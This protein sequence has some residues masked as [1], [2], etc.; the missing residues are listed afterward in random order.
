LCGGG[1]VWQWLLGSIPY[2]LVIYTSCGSKTCINPQ[3][4]RCGFQADANRAGPNTTL[5]PSDIAEIRAAKKTALPGS[6]RALAQHYADRFGVE[7]G[8]IRE[9]WNGTAWKKRQRN[10]RAGRAKAVRA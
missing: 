1:C 2:G 7:P 8:Q 4:L 9:I 6:T 10:P 5:L 3:H